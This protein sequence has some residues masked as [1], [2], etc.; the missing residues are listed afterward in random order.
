MGI[1]TEITGPFRK[2]D[3]NN[4]VAMAMILPKTCDTIC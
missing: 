4:T 1:A 3:D 2:I